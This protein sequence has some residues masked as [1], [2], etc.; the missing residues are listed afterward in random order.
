MGYVPFHKSVLV[1]RIVGDRSTPKQRAMARPF[2][3]VDML[4]IARHSRNQNTSVSFQLS[5]FGNQL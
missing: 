5:A 3:T 2:T 4:D 1:K